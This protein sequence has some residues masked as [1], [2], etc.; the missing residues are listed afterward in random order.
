MCETLINKSELKAKIFIAKYK[1]D[2][3]EK[4]ISH[5]NLYPQEYL[6]I[7][8]FFRVIFLFIISFLLG[9]FLN[10]RYVLLNQNSLP[11]NLLLSTFT[12]VLIFSFITCFIYILLMKNYIKTEYN[13]KI[14]K[15]I[16]YS[17]AEG[18]L[19]KIGVENE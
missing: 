7:R 12:L 11:I 10:V 16:Q 13:R 6:F 14:Y 17:K 18:Y 4:D 19:K 1:K 5:V 9:T 15:V 3:I 8:L 2:N